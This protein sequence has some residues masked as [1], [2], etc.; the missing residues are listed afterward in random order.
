MGSGSLQLSRGDVEKLATF[1]DE[2]SILFTDLKGFTAMSQMLHPAQVRLCTAMCALPCVQ[3]CTMSP[4][5]HKWH[6]IAKYLFESLQVHLPRFVGSGP[7]LSQQPV[8]CLRC[9]AGKPRCLQSGDHRGQ[10]GPTIG[11]H[12]V[13]LHCPVLLSQTR[14]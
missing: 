14:H 13:M 8:L 4:I 10:V 7:A 1:H 12:W 3:L 11:D 6:G 2:V 5:Y 9:S